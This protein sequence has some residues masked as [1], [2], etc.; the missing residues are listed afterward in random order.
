[1][2]LQRTL[3]AHRQATLGV[4]PHLVEGGFVWA[5][6]LLAVGAGFGAGVDIRCTWGKILP[7]TPALSP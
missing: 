1:M 5:A 3:L 2:H 4:G 6:H 7:L